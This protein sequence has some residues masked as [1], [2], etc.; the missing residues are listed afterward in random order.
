M[1]RKII[2][3]IFKTPYFRIMKKEETIDKPKNPVGRQ[4]KGTERRISA[5]LSTTETALAAAKKHFGT[6]GEALE[7]AVKYHKEIADLEKAAKKA[8]SAK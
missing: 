5:S 2:C 3:Q 6:P 8:A 4:M 7:M 1:M